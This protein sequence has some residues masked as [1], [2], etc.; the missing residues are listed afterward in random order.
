MVIILLKYYKEYYHEY[1]F[2]NT[3]PYDRLWFEPLSKEYG[4]KIHFI[5]SSLMPDTVILASGFDAVCIL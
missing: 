5:E 1:R 4:M 2:F 3:K